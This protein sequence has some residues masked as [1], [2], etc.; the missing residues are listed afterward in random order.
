MTNDEAK[1]RAEDAKQLLENK[2]FR[3]AFK[4][5]SEYLESKALS[6]DPDNREMAQR[7]VI[8]KQLLAAIKREIERHIDNGLIAD[9]RI[10]ELEKRRLFAAFRR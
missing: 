8:S 6:C 9:V 3:E 2:M 7:V 10:S 4:A 5:V 1:F